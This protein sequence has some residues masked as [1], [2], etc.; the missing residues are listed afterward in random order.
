MENSHSSTKT[1]FITFGYHL[2]DV[3]D[4]L[5]K[6][7]DVFMSCR[8]DALSSRQKERGALLSALQDMVNIIWAGCAHVEMYGSCATQLDLP[9][10]DLDAVIRGLDRPEVV[11]VPPQ[12]QALHGQ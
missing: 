9:S 7:V 4:R 10:L 3:C 5:S 1:F 6:D 11:I 2:L 12:T 8:A